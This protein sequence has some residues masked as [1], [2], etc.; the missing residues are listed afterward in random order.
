MH[1][2]PS[3]RYAIFQGLRSVVATIA[4]YFS[5]SEAEAISSENFD[6]DMRGRDTFGFHG[7][8]CSS[9]TLSLSNS[10]PPFDFS[11]GGVLGYY[12]PRESR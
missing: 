6:R 9:G 3:T 8:D 11:Y 2:H 7:F 5:S 4:R 10:L 1:P 12:P